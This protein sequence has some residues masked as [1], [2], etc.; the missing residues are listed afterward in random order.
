MAQKYNIASLSS[1]FRI[2]IRGKC[3]GNVLEWNNTVQLSTCQCFFFVCIKDHV[4]KYWNMAFAFVG[5]SWV[6]KLA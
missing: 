6:L 2:Y 3:G 1:M 5:F 4:L